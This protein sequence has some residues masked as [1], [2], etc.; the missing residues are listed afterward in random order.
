MVKGEFF[1]P[2]VVCEQCVTNNMKQ[3]LKQEH[4]NRLKAAFMKALQQ[5]QEIEARLAQVRPSQ[6]KFLLFYY[7]G[8][9]IDGFYPRIF[10]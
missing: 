6:V 2:K 8:N 1:E 9:R 3:T 10:F 4:T 7:S 5:E